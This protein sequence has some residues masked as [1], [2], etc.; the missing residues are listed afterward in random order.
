MSTRVILLGVIGCFL[1]GGAYSFYKQGVP[2]I[3]TIIVGVLAVLALTGAV[4]W[5]V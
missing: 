1:A 3:G 5:A 2:I 4:L